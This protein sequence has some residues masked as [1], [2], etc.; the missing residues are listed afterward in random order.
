MSKILSLLLLVTLFWSCKQ[1]ELKKQVRIGFNPWPG[2]EV[3]YLA[4][5]LGYYEEEG[6]DVKLVELGSLGD[7]RSAF[8]KGSIDVASSTNIE[9]VQVRSRMKKQAQAFCVFNYSNGGDVILSRESI[10]SVKDLKGKTV[11]AEGGSLNVYVLQRALEKNGLSLKDVKVS[12]LDQSSMK[13]AFERGELDALVTY[14]PF[15][16]E[17]SH[18]HKVNQIF[19]TKEIPAEVL[20]IL[21]AD[22]QYIVENQVTLQKMLKAMDR[23]ID[24]MYA[25]K[26]E[27]YAIMAAR[28]KISSK[29]FQETIENDLQVLRFKDQKA[30]FQAK[31]TVEKALLKTFEVMKNTD[32]MKGDLGAENLQTDLIIQSFK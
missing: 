29:E 28:Q 32:N 3:I 22:K 13:G 19:S 26:E 16:I 12:Y 8:E 27:A 21:V 5:H 14:P 23:A 11:A 24:Y 31:G 10:K 15:S 20:D 25:N 1:E 17:L 9:L 7:T 6:V 18:A 4:K 30:L 2:Y